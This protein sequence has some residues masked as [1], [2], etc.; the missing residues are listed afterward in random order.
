MIFVL[1]PAF[2]EEKA[3]PT[4]IPK[5]NA[6]LSKLNEGYK[7]IVC[8]DG[9]TDSTQKVLEEF[10]P[11][12]PLEIIRHKI[13]RGLGESSRDLF[14]F[15]N[16][17]SGSGDVIVRLDCDDTHEPEFIGKLINKIR[18]GYDVVVASRF[19]NGGGQLGVNSYRTFISYVATSCALHV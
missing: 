5:L 13:N 19:A 3:L 10:L 12:M 7:I 18:E 2:N 17:L 14:E 16:D 4:L 15:A 8:N 1:L 6:E 9:S 11:S